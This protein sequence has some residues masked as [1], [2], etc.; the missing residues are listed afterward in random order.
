MLFGDLRKMLV[1]RRVQKVA[2]QQ[3]E[4]SESRD[5]PL[6]DFRHT[7]AWVLLGEPGS[8][9]SEA[10]RMEAEETGGEFLTAS[11]FI[12]SHSMLSHWRG[13][14]LFIDAMDEARASGT[15]S[16]TLRIANQLRQ[17][18]CPAF[19]LS[20]RAADW[21]GSMDKADLQDLSPDGKLLTLQLSPLTDSDIGQI[22]QLNHGVVDPDDFVALAERHDIK[23]LLNNPQTL[24]LIAKAIQEDQWPES[25]EQ[26]YRLA[27]EKLA[28][29]NDR[30]HRSHKR[31]NA[32]DNKTVTQAAGQLFATLL[33]AGK[34]G[35][36]RDDEAGSDEFPT[37]Q[38][39]SPE[40]PEATEHA[41][42]SGLFVPSGQHDEQLIPCH[43]SVAEYLAAIWLADKLDKHLLPLK[44]LLNLLLG[45][46]GGV[47]AD[48]RGLFAWLA[49]SSVTA[50]HRLINI[51]PL[52][53]VLYGDSSPF[54]PADKRLLL[55]SLR[56]KAEAFPG[57]RWH[58]R[59]D[60]EAFGALADP[61]LVDDF[62]TILQNEDREEAN[63]SHMDCVLEI[64]QHGAAMP[65][66]AET[67]LS[68]VK[69]SDLWLRL[70][71]GALKAWLKL[72][73][74]EDA[75]TL[76]DLINTG[77]VEDSDDELLAKLLAHL[78]PDHLAPT[79]LIQSLHIP[80]DSRLIGG[81]RM[82]WDHDLIESAPIEHL[83]ELL[84]SFNAHT[85]VFD[86]NHEL[87]ELSRAVG[88]LVAKTLEAYGDSATD[89]DIYEWLGAGAGAG[90]GADKYGQIS[91]DAETQSFLTQWFVDRPNRYKALLKRCIHARAAQSRA[92]HFAR[93]PA[94]SAPS[95]IGSW[96]LHEASTE[97]EAIGKVCLANAVE[98]LI[99]NSPSDLTLETL[100][101]WSHKNSQRAS[102]L[103]EF[104]FCHID[105][106][107]SEHAKSA[108][109][110]REKF[111]DQR[112]QRT[113]AIT[114]LLDEIYSGTAPAHTLDHL[115]CVWLGHFSDIRGKTISERFANYSDLGDRLMHAAESGFKLSLQRTD[116]PSSDDIIALYLKKQRYWISQAC[117]LGLQLLWKEDSPQILALP[118]T[119]TE[120]LLA[121]RISTV[122]L[123]LKEWLA[124]TAQ[125]RPELFA[126]LLIRYANAALQ[127]GDTSLEITHLIS[128]SDAF[129]QVAAL[130]APEILKS[131]P[132]R[133][134]KQNLGALE[135]LMEVVH[136]KAPDQLK[137]LAEHKLTLKGMDS[138]QKTLWYSLA[139][140]LEPKRYEKQLWRHVGKSN[141]R[142]ALAAEYLCERRTSRI[143]G[144]TIPEYTLGRLIELITPNADF[145]RASG[146]VSEAMKRGDQVR[147][148]INMLG[149]ST[150]PEAEKIL[151]QLLE[152][153]AL[154]QVR[155]KIQDTLHQQHSKR[156]EE[157]FRFSTVE[158]VALVLAN[159]A[160]T[161]NADLSA[162][163]LSYLDEIAHEIRTANDD[164][165]RTF[166]NI[167]NGK[168]DGP[169][170]ENLCRDDI[171]RILR[172]RLNAHGISSTP[173]ADHAGDKR[174]DL[175]LDYRNQLTLPIEIKR[176][177]HRDLWKALRNQLIAQYIHSP[178]SR[179][180]GI[181]LVL[182]FKDAK[183]PMPAP[184]DGDRKPKSPEELQAR[185]TAMLNEEECRRIFVRVL[186]VSWPK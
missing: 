160:P 14:T 154:Q 10:L 95:D 168:P 16:L 8:G 49:Q 86:E 132:L 91:R 133:D 37:A 137:P 138:A 155:Y 78:Y 45:Y 142:A 4:K 99:K 22:L 123:E 2:E 119:L 81:Y 105:E 116:L 179:G 153:P 186:D 15:D 106:W 173:E 183:H 120:Q 79:Q 117:L 144:S 181:Y 58:L 67:L 33:L 111:K 128:Q 140:L 38:Q 85:A 182:W 29:E 110:Y 114:P 89:G 26:V 135:Q 152:Q 62:R 97:S 53:I 39:L 139:L 35:I 124:Q 6:A 149:A 170:E 48:L 178:K 112:H 175:Y 118:D 61:A 102:L 103:E 31:N 92:F 143:R 13:K 80:K 167:T 40:D 185:L 164:G 52:G 96:Y 5:L 93:L 169:R 158:S 82:F 126:N 64:L 130:A 71:T 68:V 57:F 136:A 147:S 174:A 44:R 121:F 107:R 90:A 43:R 19:R 113:I 7:P 165:Y 56:K 145:E 24:N 23:Q 122:H 12:N 125:Q 129:D 101:N 88:R 150:T 77:L 60:Q 63:Q 55:Q 9:K 127:Q 74:P 72:C 161:D 171:Y 177:S 151:Q 1:A 20:C 100:A 184:L 84:S 94:A 54:S 159:Q 162:L 11:T 46:D 134:K 75:K 27:C 18:D 108:N 156:R 21:L 32:I 83:P 172:P 50:R 30:R 36:A 176:D 59:H 66:L 28:Y 17:L 41:L 157:Q 141:T 148:I 131:F 87:G 109:E 104:L 98:L 51:D 166:W 115:S 65:E 25:R 76:L 47:V 73:H 34:S 180:Y 42:Q 163:C 70:R 3:D 69:D 146:F